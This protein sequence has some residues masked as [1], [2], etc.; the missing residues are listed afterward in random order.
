MRTQIKY[1]CCCCHLDYCN[2]LLYSLPDLTF[3]KLQRIQI[4]VAV[5]FTTALLNSVILLLFSK[6]CTGYLS[7]KELTTKS[8]YSHL[9]LFI[10]WLLPTC[11]TWSLSLSLASMTFAVPATEQA[12]RIFALNPKKTSCWPCIYACCTYSLEQSACWPPYLSHN[13]TIQV[14]TVK[15]CVLHLDGREKTKPK[16]YLGLS[17]GSPSNNNCYRIFLCWC[18]AYISKQFLHIE[19]QT[20]QP[21]SFCV[22]V[23]VYTS[24]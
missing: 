5:W 21:F 9:K 14:Q 10:N 15:N 3:C 23:F 2:S 7:F 6:S 8:C 17:T 19:K 20:L 18:S 16:L 4:H 12:F 11:K 22:L 24:V 13:W 1:C